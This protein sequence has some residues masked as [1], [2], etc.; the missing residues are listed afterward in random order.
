MHYDDQLCGIMNFG[1]GT[2][3]LEEQYNFGAC[4]M[5]VIIPGYYRLVSSWHALEELIIIQVCAV[6]FLY[7]LLAHT[8]LLHR[9]LVL[10]YHL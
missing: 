3:F 8:P 9:G 2:S 4:L 6:V 7:T 5:I 1:L 10:A